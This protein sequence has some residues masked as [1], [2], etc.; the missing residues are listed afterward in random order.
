MRLGRVLRDSKNK[1]FVVLLLLLGGRRLEGSDNGLGQV[2]VLFLICRLQ[3]L[4]S[5]KTSLSLS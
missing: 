1:T 3:V 5:S 2:S 4:T